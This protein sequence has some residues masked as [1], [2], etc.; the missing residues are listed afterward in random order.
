MII[1][2]PV[3]NLFKCVNIQLLIKFA[4]PIKVFLHQAKSH[5]KILGLQQ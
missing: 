5:N 1:I 3:F 2:N 4:Y